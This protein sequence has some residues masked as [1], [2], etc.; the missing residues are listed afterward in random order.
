MERFKNDLGVTFYIK[1]FGVSRY[2][3]W[4][5]IGNPSWQDRL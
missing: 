5:V 2:T 3:N 4:M 1:E